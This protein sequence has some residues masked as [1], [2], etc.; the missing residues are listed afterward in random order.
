MV[1]VAVLAALT[2]GAGLLG[3]LWTGL[4]SQDLGL[5]LW[6][7]DQFWTSFVPLFIC[8]EDCVGRPTGASLFPASPRPQKI[9]KFIL[10][11]TKTRVI[12]NF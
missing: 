10:E 12:V 3:L 7:L 8:R 6:T 1:P 9:Q 2:A 11:T 5:H 4:L